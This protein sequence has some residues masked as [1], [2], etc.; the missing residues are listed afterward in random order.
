MTSKKSES[1]MRIFLLREKYIL[2][3]M[4]VQDERLY[5]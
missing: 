5:F 4:H 3:K 1:L 2:A